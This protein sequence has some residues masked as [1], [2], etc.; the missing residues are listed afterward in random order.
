MLICLNQ[1]EITSSFSS[2]GVGGGG[3]G[4]PPPPPFSLRVAR[5]G[6][7]PYSDASGKQGGFKFSE[8]D[9][10]AVIKDFNSKGRDVVIDYEHQTLNGGQ[11]PAAG[12]ISAL[13]KKT[14]GLYATVKG[15]TAR[16][17]EYIKN[18]EYR[19]ISPVL[20]IINGAPVALHSVALTNQPALHDLPALAAMSQKTL[21]NTNNIG[22]SMKNLLSKLGLSAFSEMSEDAA[23]AVTTEVEKLLALKSGQESFLS[24]HSV[25]SLPEMTEKIKGLVPL[26]EKTALETELKKRDAQAAVDKVLSENKISEAQKSGAMDFAMRDLAAFNAFFAKAPAVTPTNKVPEQAKDTKTEP[27]PDPVQLKVFSTLGLSPEEQLLALK[28]TPEKK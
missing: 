3:A 10:D 18:K 24:L 21:L 15:W 1:N 26:S 14:D 2:T 11:A 22:D 13:E 25:K 8:A 19:F 6:D 12:W 17:A 28:G 27:V 4:S 20:R 5:Y 23:K 7:N 9:A 16:A